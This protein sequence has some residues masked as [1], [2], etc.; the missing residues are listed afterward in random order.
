MLGLTVYEY[1]MFSTRFRSVCRL[2]ACT[3]SPKRCLCN[4]K[5]LKT[6]AEPHLTLITDLYEIWSSSKLEEK[7]K[8]RFNKIEPEYNKHAFFVIA[9]V[10]VN[11]WP[12]G[13]SLR[14]PRG[15]QNALD[16][17]LVPA[18]W[19]YFV[20]LSPNNNFPNQK[21]RLFSE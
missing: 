17:V 5:T 11:M 19:V 2:W 1:A 16:V 12:T 3:F 10:A 6:V 13:A 8:S 7:N 21:F 20:T 14:K 4:K 18:K 15:I 9:A